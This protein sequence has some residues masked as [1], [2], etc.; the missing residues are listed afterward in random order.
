M[1]FQFTE[2]ITQPIFIFFFL[3]AS[4]IFNF[5]LKKD[6]FDI[7]A[8]IFDFYVIKFIHKDYQL[9]NYH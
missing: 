6:N 3:K 7:Q 5:S 9:K 4:L 1:N 8:K 2:K